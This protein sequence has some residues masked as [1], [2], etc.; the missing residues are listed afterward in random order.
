MG[1][2][3]PIFYMQIKRQCI[4]FTTHTNFSLWENMRR[5]VTHYSL[6]KRKKKIIHLTRNNMPSLWLLP[7]KRNPEAPI[8]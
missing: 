2:I 8:E 4:P 7:R 1:V 5:T 3:R 6:K